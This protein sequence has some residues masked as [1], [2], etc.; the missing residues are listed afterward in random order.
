M[1]LDEK[2]RFAAASLAMLKAGPKRKPK[3]EPG[4]NTRGDSR[5]EK[6]VAAAALLQRLR[7][8]ADAAGARRAAGAHSCDGDANACLRRALDRVPRDVQWRVRQAIIAATPHNI[9][10]PER[11]ARQCTAARSL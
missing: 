6:A 2:R 5:I 3:A 9:G 10:A 11:E 7:L 1:R 8:M 4:A